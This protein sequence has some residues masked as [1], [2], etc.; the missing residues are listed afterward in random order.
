MKLEVSEAVMILA[1]FLGSMINSV[2]GEFLGIL[3]STIFGYT[4]K[5]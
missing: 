3:T 2:G 4:K 1:A 5:L